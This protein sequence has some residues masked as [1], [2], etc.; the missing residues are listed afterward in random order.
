MARLTHPGG[1]EV[2]HREFMKRPQSEPVFQGISSLHHLLDIRRTCTLIP[3]NDERNITAIVP[4]TLFRLPVLAGV[5]DPF[6]AAPTKP[7]STCRARQM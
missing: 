1:G 4:V 6:S 3:P 7:T 5:G 2:R